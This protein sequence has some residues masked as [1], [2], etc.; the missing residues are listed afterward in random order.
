MIAN[1]FDEILPFI[2]NSN[3][4]I[5]L[6]NFELL[7]KRSNFKEKFIAGLKK[8]PYKDGIE[9]LFYNIWAAT[10]KIPGKYDE[11]LDKDVLT[12]LATLD[13]N[14]MFYA[15]ILNRVNE[16]NQKLFLNFY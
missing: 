9:E 10:N 3:T 5:L 13:V 15:T 1:Y 6:L 12:A 8:Y 14:G 11:F 16:E 2:V 7:M 4:N